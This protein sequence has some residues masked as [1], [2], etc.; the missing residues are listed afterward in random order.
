MIEKNSQIKTRVSHPAKLGQMRLCFHVIFIILLPS[1]AS[2]PWCVFHLS[3]AILNR[4]S[5]P[6]SLCWCI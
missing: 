6:A 5:F 2:Y 4:K 3:V 1:H